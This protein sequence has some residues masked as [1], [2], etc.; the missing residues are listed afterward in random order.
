MRWIYD[1]GY[2]VRDTDDK[3]YRIAGTAEDVTS[4]MEAE[5]ELMRAKEQA[6]SASRAKSAFLAN[7]SHEIRTPMNA[8]IG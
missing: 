4:V 5:A 7:I 8:I 3:V 2:P 6:E 1:R